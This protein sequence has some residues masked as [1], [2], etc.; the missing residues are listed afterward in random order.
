MIK[1]ACPHCRSEQETPDNYVGQVI[2]CLGCDADYVVKPPAKAAKPKGEEGGRFRIPPIAGIAAMAVMALIAL[3]VPVILFVTTKDDGGGAAGETPVEA[4]RRVEVPGSYRS[5]LMTFLREGTRMRNLSAQGPTYAEL[6]AGL[7]DV[8]EAWVLARSKWPDN[9]S[10]N[11]TISSFEKS[12]DAWDACL[13]LWKAK[14]E[15]KDNPTAPDLNYWE[16]YT[17]KFNGDLVIRTRPRGYIP[18]EYRGRAFLPFDENIDALMG[19]AAE[20]FT[21]GKFRI[22]QQVK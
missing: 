17:K 5:S 14:N 20:N 18:K 9:F 2:R 10:D 1:T 15:M 22:L 12:I 16:F 21:D 11:T 3:V 4:F 8:S 7:D 19:V 13:E 6:V